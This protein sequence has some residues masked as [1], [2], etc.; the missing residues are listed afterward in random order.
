MFSEVDLLAFWLAKRAEAENQN[1]RSR[2][3]R[4]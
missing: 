1:R 2:E 4:K 3:G